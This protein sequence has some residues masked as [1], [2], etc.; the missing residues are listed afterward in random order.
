MPQSEPITVGQLTINYLIDGS[1]NG[2]M[3]VFELTVPPES[4]VPPPHRHS[5]NDEFVYVLEGILRYT[6]DDVARELR[7]GEWM[8]SPRGSVHQF[9]NASKEVT[10]ALVTLSPDIGARYFQDVA[11]VVNV[12]GAPDRARLASVMSSYGLVPVAPR[13]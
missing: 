4:N 1:G 3:G 9:S 5:Q 2:G 8:F 10:R 7:P 6:V 13:I 11:A 12:G